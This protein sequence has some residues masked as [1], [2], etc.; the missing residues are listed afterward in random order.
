MDLWSINPIT[1]EFDKVGTG[2]V[3]S[4]GS[5]IETISGGIRNSSWHFFGPP[6]SSGP[7]VKKKEPEVCPL[8]A[9]ATSSCEMYSG[10]LLETHELVT[11]RSQEVTRGIVLTYDSLRADPR[12]IVRFT[13][14]ELDPNQ[15][16]VPSA[17]R[18]IAELDVS[19][20]GITTEVPG[21]AG[22]HGLNGNKNIWR[23]EPE[24][25]SVG[26]ALQVDLRDQPTGVYDYTLRSGMLG[27]AGERGFIGTLNESTGQF[28]SVNSRN[29]YLGS[30]WGIAGLLE[31]VENSDG[32]VLIINGDG[33]ET[34]YPEQADGQYDRPSGEFARLSKL[35]NGTFQRVWPDQTVER[36][37]SNKK[38]ISLT[39]RNG[40]ETRYE[41]DSAERL[42]KLTD[43]VGLETTLSYSPG[44]V[45]INDPASRK[46]RLNLDG[47]GNLI[48][49][50]DPDGS[51]HNGATIASIA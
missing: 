8:Q 11:Y 45:E 29:S 2:Q 7:R 42:T 43:P 34:L 4:N 20:N 9:E 6:A 31:L 14:D 12:P 5:V 33:S 27:Y 26:A 47:N 41:Y 13:F 19:R 44:V 49:V 18:L 24:A 37:G 38:L 22:G 39:D 30:G 35:P 21:F 36:Y 25:G 46:T 1:G 32:S 23:L 10:A 51:T 16:S 3:S 50:T 28:T 15:F 40:N 48:R 17:V